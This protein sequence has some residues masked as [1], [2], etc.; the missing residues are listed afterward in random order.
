MYDETRGPRMGRGGGDVLVV[1]VMTA[2]LSAD[3]VVAEEAARGD[4]DER[5]DGSRMPPLTQV[6]PRVAA[7]T[8]EQ[9]LLR[10]RQW[11]IDTAR[12]E[13]LVML[14]LGVANGLL[15]VRTFPTYMQDPTSGFS[16]S[17]FFYFFIIIVRA[18]AINRLIC[19]SANQAE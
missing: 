14:V 17:C 19:T 6:K 3:A 12:R 1:P 8:T 2:M 9:L 15:R 18:T 13:D 7:T 11:A 5:A 16:N 4:E 10:D